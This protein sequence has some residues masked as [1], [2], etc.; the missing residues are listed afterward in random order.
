MEATV[1]IKEK[2]TVYEPVCYYTTEDDGIKRF[3]IVVNFLALKCSFF[4]LFVQ[5]YLTEDWFVLLQID[6]VDD[7]YVLRRLLDSGKLKNEK[8]KSKP[9]INSKNEKRKSKSKKSKKTNRIKSK[10]K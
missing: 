1:N 6:F 9:K 5:A 3:L 2:M 4:S 10:I 7:K 8:E